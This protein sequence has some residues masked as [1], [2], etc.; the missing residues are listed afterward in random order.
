MTRIAYRR[1]RSAR[2]VFTRRLPPACSRRANRSSGSPPWTAGC[3][4]GRQSR[5][6]RRARAALRSRLPCRP[7]A[8]ERGAHAPAAPQIAVD[9]DPKAVG[10]FFFFAVDEHAAIGELR[11]ITGVFLAFPDFAAKCLQLLMETLP[12]LTHVAAL[13]DLSRLARLSR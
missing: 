6:W 1:A 10:R 13:W 9:V 2:D 5:R 8:V 7:D 11:S 3:G 4:S 12:R